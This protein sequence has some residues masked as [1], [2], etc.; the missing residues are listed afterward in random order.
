MSARFFI[1][2]DDVWTLDA[3]FRYFFDMA[4]DSGIPV[5]H[6][7][8]PGKM[9]QGIVRFLCRAKEKTPQ[10]LD[11]VQHGWVHADHS[12]EAGIKYEFG[13]SRDYGSQ[14]MDI[15]L[16]LNKMRLAFGKYFTSAFV[17]PYHGY[18]A[19]TLEVLHKEGFQVF[20]AGTRR[21]D[22]K[23]RFI[24]MPA[25]VSFSRYEDGKTGIHEAREVVALLAQGIHRRPLSGVVTH[26]ADFSNAVSRRELK[27]FF[28]FIAAL[29]VKE[30]W[31][32]LLFSD[33]L[34]G[35]KGE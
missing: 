8:I 4:L 6:A 13:H 9:D 12:L 22:G 10:L 14:Q 24:A 20:S 35:K 25:H 5:V 3:R 31:Q 29:R 21:L 17:P 34:S 11:I 27:K 32:A 26:H 19:R 2:N 7:V 30:K 1:R 16:G 33:I 28:D 15:Q 18:D 23:D